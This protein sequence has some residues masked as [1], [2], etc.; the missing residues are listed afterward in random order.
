MP[1]RRTSVVGPIA[2][3]ERADATA[4][5]ARR[6]GPH[7]PERAR[8]KGRYLP[9]VSGAAASVTGVSEQPPA[10]MPGRDE[11]KEHDTAAS[12]TSP[13]DEVGP[14]AHEEVA[15]AGAHDLDDNDPGQVADEPATPLF[16]MDPDLARRIGEQVLAPLQPQLQAI[17]EQLTASLADLAAPLQLQAAAIAR[18][19]LAGIAWPTFHF[20]LPDELLESLSRLWDR[21][22]PPNWSTAGQVGPIVDVVTQDGLP[23]VWVPRAGIVT[24]VVHAADHA[25]RVQILLA[26]QEEVLEDCDAVLDDMAAITT[27]PARPGDLMLARQAVQALRQGL[28]AAAQALAAAVLESTIT[29]QVTS[30]TKVKDRVRFD[31]DSEL[32]ELRLRVALAPL[33]P[34]FR[35]FTPG[36]TPEDRR[37]LGP[38]RHLTVHSATPEHLSPANAL[39]SVMLLVSVLRALQDLPALRASGVDL[40][41]LTR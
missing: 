11:E 8:D 33:E 3:G 12:A 4:G 27:A 23:L 16:A 18:E 22:L 41:W 9:L 36:Q 19:A 28:E 30:S 25:A 7:Q 14:P 1:T 6:S 15:A 40:S 17:G 35:S 39:V 20:S 5:H 31:E 24:T 2:V 29:A 13:E 26:H 37:P 10:E 32:V 38:N 34:Y 21:A